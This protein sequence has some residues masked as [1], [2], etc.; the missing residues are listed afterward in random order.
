MIS[1]DK[2]KERLQKAGSLSVNRLAG[3]LLRLSP[4]VQHLRCLGSHLPFR[5]P[6]NEA[7]RAILLWANSIPS[8]LLEGHQCDDWEPQVALELPPLP[9][10]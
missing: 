4:V 3:E 1:C 8:R 5:G 6:E 9:S 10:T 7:S 2:Y